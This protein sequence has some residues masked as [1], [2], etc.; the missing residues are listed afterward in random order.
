M[1]KFLSLF[2]L[3]AIA[4]LCNVAYAETVTV[5]DVIKA[6]N[7]KATSTSYTNF[8]NVTITSGA[9]YAGN[10][11]KSDDGAIQLRSKNSES[12]IVST[13][14]VGKVKKVVVEWN[15]STTSG[16][17]LDVYGKNSAYTAA[18]DLYSTSKGTKLGSI[19]YGKSTELEI[20]GDYEY[21]GLRSSS[22]A[23]ILTSITITW[24]NTIIDV[25][26]IAKYNDQSLNS[27]V[28]FSCPLTITKA[29]LGYIFVKDANGDFGCI[30]T[31]TTKDTDYP[32]G[33][34]IPAGVTGLKSEYNRI[35]AKNNFATIGTPEEG[36]AVTPKDVAYSDLKKN[37]NLYGY[38]K[39]AAVPVV[40]DSS[41]SCY[42]AYSTDT[43]AEGMLLSVDGSGVEITDGKT[44]NLTGIVDTS[45]GNAFLRV[46]AAE[47]VVAAF[48]K[49]TISLEAG[50]YDEVKEA[51]ITT[52]DGD[53][54][55][56]TTKDTDVLANFDGTLV[57]SKT[58]TVKIDKSCTLR[59]IATNEE[60][61][62][63]EQASAT[64][65]MKT[66][67][68][69]ITVDNETKVATITTK[70]A[71]NVKIYYTLDGTAATTESALYAKPFVVSQGETVNAVA[72]YGEFE[73]SDAA[74]PFEF[75]F[76]TL[77]ES[78]DVT[79]AEDFNN[80]ESGQ[81]VENVTFTKGIVSIKFNQAESQYAPKYNSSKNNFQFYDK[82]TMTVSVVGAIVTSVSFDCS[83]DNPVSSASATSGK[84]V[85]GEW[86]N[87]NAQTATLTNTSGKQ[88]KVKVFTI[89]YLVP[90][91]AVSVTAVKTKGAYYTVNF[92]LN[93]Q[94]A[95]DGVLYA[96]TT[97]PSAKPSEPG[98]DFFD[99]SY[100]DWDWKNKYDQHDWVAINGNTG[101]VGKTLTTGFIARYDG[102]KLTPVA[103]IADN[104]D[105]AS[106]TLN[107][108]GVAN[109]FY[110]NYENTSDF[111][112]T[113]VHGKPYYPFFVKA[114]VNEVANYVGEVKA[115]TGGFELWGSGVCGK[116]N[117]K[118]LEIDAN[119][120]EITASTEYKQIEGVLVADAAANGG[121]KLVALSDPTIP[122]GAAALKA[123][124]K[125]TV[126]GTEGAVVV[127]GAD[128]KVM[129][130]DAM[131][132]MVKS[133]NAEGAATVAM[134]AGYYIVRTAGTAAK[135][136]VK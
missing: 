55:L 37:E 68:P 122:T 118:G 2:C 130:F 63:G 104:G 129:I 15:T 93:G 12:G 46:F 6:S 54:I 121:V 94:V 76:N 53:Y 62:V 92:E 26:N 79:V 136:M 13:T 60:M 86:V 22:G 4:W 18:T 135:V 71:D 31:Q 40:Y 84:L 102:V 100:E 10:S 48:A 43:S 70:Y 123:D 47:E 1:K 29:I 25:A 42:Y 120:I 112:W 11:G 114:K 5:N 116:L 90:D 133:V 56:Y 105:A 126:Y 77:S 124:G 113:D 41:N 132:R 16:R 67:A 74:S 66:A 75:P 81:T 131:G 38:V 108:F 19:T 134:P 117:E 64:Y 99:K 82:N 44:Y 115:V 106:Y 97:E 3:I 96:R 23:L 35:N 32:D 65:V 87:I 7:L 125:A 72:Q 83:S 95:N 34:V 8:S 73:V 9:V 103:A 119:G 88:A 28:R 49:P 57:K 110:G 80:T 17:E 107:T 109:V 14:S 98:K 24:E 33:Y 78:F 50:S 21:I 30:Y 51:T 58:A 91:E 27:L 89:S 52:T 36:S 128:G 59:A 39:V 111:G 127:N 101:L 85:D 45:S 61:S 69:T 20:T